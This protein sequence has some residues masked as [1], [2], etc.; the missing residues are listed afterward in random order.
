M[1]LTFPRLL[2]LVALLIVILVELRTVL[3]FFE[4]ELPFAATI[5]IGIVGIVALLLWAFLSND[6]PSER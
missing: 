2:L 6:A 3:A 4:I 5:A 1:R